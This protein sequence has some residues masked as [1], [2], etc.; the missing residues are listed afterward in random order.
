MENKRL[1]TEDDLTRLINEQG[2]TAADIS[3][4]CLRVELDDV[5]YHW[6]SPG[7]GDWVRI[8]NK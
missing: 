7:T 6:H 2:K 3:I 5:L 4:I 8:G 1:P